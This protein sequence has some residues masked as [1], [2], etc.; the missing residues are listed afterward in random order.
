MTRAEESQAVAGDPAGEGEA[1]PTTE[2]PGHE[3]PQRAAL[4]ITR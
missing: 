3:Q 2:G 4:S 1:M